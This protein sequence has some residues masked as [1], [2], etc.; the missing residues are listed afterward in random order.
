MAFCGYTDAE[1]EAWIELSWWLSQSH[2]DAWWQDKQEKYQRLQ[3]LRLIRKAKEKRE[4]PGEIKRLVLA[5]S[6]KGVND[7]KGKH[8]KQ[9]ARGKQDKHCRPSDKGKQDKHCRA[10]DKLGKGKHGKHCGGTPMMP[11][12]TPDSQCRF[13]DLECPSESV[14]DITEATGVIDGLTFL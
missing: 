1:W 2:Y 10:S 6:N 5:G 7:G 9:A 3:A 8:N 12:T 14:F 4:L 13:Q 11:A